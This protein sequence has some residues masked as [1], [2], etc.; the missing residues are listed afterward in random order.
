MQP[1]SYAGHR[2]PVDLIC[3]AIWRYLRFTLSYRDVEYLLSERGV[4]E[5]YETI[6]RWVVK[7][8]PTIWRNLRRQLPR[9]TAQCWCGRPPTPL[10]M[11]D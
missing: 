11:P 6:R 10:I 9:P 3:H 4:D 5:S 8:G 2:F 7:F 1:I